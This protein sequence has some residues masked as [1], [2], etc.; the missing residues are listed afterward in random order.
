MTTSHGGTRMPRR[1]DSHP[2]RTRWIATVGAV[3]LMTL[4]LWLFEPGPITRDIPA[5]L[6]VG[7]GVFLM[8]L[9]LT[10]KSGDGKKK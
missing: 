3:A 6:G 9:D 1:S 10:R 8:T 2:A 4:L 5:I 7:L